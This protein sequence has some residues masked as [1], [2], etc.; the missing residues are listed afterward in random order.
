MRK[1]WLVRAGTVALVAG[2]SLPVFAQPQPVPTAPPATQ[3]AKDALQALEQA[4]EALRKAEAEAARAA[5]QAQAARNEALRAEERA[6]VRTRYVR[7]REKQEAALGKYWIGVGSAPVPAVVSAQLGLPESTGLVIEDVVPESPAAKA[8]LE[9][10]DVVAAVGDKNLQSLEDLIAV[11]QASEGKEIEITFYRTGKRQSAKLTPAERPKEHFAFTG[12]GQRY[13]VQLGSEDGVQFLRP[14]VVFARK[15]ELPKELTISVTRK[16]KEP[17]TA[18]V[19][20][21]GKKYQATLETVDQLPEGVREHVRMLLTGGGQQMMMARM[22]GMAGMGDMSM[23]PPM[24]LPAREA[25][26]VEKQLRDIQKQIE[27]LQKAVEALQ[28]SPPA[29]NKSGAIIE[30]SDTI[31]A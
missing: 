18:E 25:Q 6:T 10:N 1:S 29:E 9:K 20:V 26:S 13:E 23:Q 2:L 28:K 19:T 17:A 4:R 12:E 24:A 31:A 22:R 14:G 7:A 15:I 3:E 27:A 16:D 5:A 8:G 30:P 11:V 21:D